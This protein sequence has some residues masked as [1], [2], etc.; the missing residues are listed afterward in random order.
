MQERISL[1]QARAII[2]ASIDHSARVVEILGT[3]IDQAEI[4]SSEHA[5][6]IGR[7]LAQSVHAGF[8]L[9]PF[10]NSA[11]DGYAVRAIDLEASAALSLQGETLAGDQRAVLKNGHCIRVTTGAILPEHADCVVMQENCEVLGNVIRFQTKPKA[12]DFVRDAGEDFH[13]NQLAIR[14]GTRLGPVQLAIAHAL[15][16]S[17]IRAYA[18]PVVTILVGGD[19]LKTLSEPLAF[20]QIYES[21]RVLLQTMVEALGARAIVAPIMRDSN[22]SVTSA[23]QQAAQH[24]DLVIS[25]GGASGGSTDFLQA[26]LQE[27]G[28]ILFYRVRVKPGMPALFG[29]IGKTHVLALPGNPVS[30]FASFLTLAKP[31]IERL[32]GR[33]ASG[34]RGYPVPLADGLRKTHTRREFLRAELIELP[35]AMAVRALEGQGSAMLRSLS[36]ADGLI[37]LPEGEVKLDA[38]DIVRF[39]PFSAMQ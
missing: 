9:P 1:D 36:L 37:D 25:A 20:G 4:Y 23:L 32:C 33:E 3:Q 8:A 5:S 22:A 30:V 13:Q 21:N 10:A 34:L 11:M 17:A 15:G 24:S 19:E 7:T 27:L 2:C 28:E 6:L 16:I 12:G 31:A 14:A 18:R 26:A 38:G 29:R 35:G 39:I